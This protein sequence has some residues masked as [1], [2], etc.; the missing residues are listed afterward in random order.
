MVVGE[1]TENHP[2]PMAS[3]PTP[4]QLLMEMTHCGPQE[5]QSNDG[6]HFDTNSA[7]EQR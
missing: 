6:A 4:P 5:E 1:V 7:S 2:E 3:E